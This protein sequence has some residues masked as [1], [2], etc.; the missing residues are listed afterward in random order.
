MPAAPANHNTHSQQPATFQHQKQYQQQQHQHQQHQQQQQQQH[1]HHAAANRTPSPLPRTPQLDFS[2]PEFYLT[3]VSA[4]LDPHMPY[5]HLQSTCLY[6][7]STA[8]LSSQDVWLSRDASSVSLSLRGERILQ[9][10]NYLRRRNWGAVRVQ[11]IARGWLARR[12]CDRI[13]AKGKNVARSMSTYERALRARQNKDM[14]A[15]PPGAGSEVLAEEEV[16]HGEKNAQAAREELLEEEKLPPR[17]R[18]LTPYMKDSDGSDEGSDR[19]VFSDMVGPE[20]MPARARAAPADTE[21]PADFLPPVRR[22]TV[23]ELPS[24]ETLESLREEAPK[25]APE[26]A[27][28]TP[29][30]PERQSSV[31]HPAL[32]AAGHPSWHQ[33]A[34]PAR[35]APPLTRQ[36]TRPPRPPQNDI[37][38]TL[39]PPQ[40]TLTPSMQSEPQPQPATLTPSMQSQPQPQTGQRSEIVNPRHSK[41]AVGLRNHLTRVSMA[42]EQILANG[43]GFQ[44]GAATPTTTEINFMKLLN[45]DSTFLLSANIAKLGPPEPADFDFLDRRRSANPE[46]SAAHYA[47]MSPRVEAWIRAT[48]KL[49]HHNQPQSDLMTHL[50]SG[51]ILCRLACEL[52]PRTQCQL[53]SKGAEFT[54]HKIIFFLELCKTVGV[55]NKNIFAVADL[56]ASDPVVDPGRRGPLK[57]VR[58]LHALERQVRRQ[59]W[60]GP[61]LETKI[62]PTQEEIAAAQAR[63]K[64]GESVY[65]MYTYARSDP[66]P[67]R[68]GP[69]KVQEV[70]DEKQLMEEDDDGG[71][72]ELSLFAAYDGKS[73]GERTLPR[74]NVTN[75]QDMYDRNADV[76]SDDEGNHIAARKRAD[77]S[78]SFVGTSDHPSGHAAGVKNA[79]ESDDDRGT[80]AGSP[81]S[82]ITASQGYSES[83]AGDHYDEGD[84]LHSD[85][86]S[87]STVRWYDT[88]RTSTPLTVITDP[89][90]GADE[91]AFGG[92]LPD[93]AVHMLENSAAVAARKEIL[94][95]V[96][97][98]VVEEAE[99]EEDEVKT[100]T[101]PGGFEEFGFRS[102]GPAAAAGSE[103]QGDDAATPTVDAEKREQTYSV[104]AAYD[105]IEHDLQPPSSPPSTPLPPSPVLPAINTRSSPAYAFLAGPPPMSALPRTPAGA[106]SSLEVPQPAP[107]HRHDQ[108]DDDA[109]SYPFDMNEEYAP[110]DAVDA[111]ASEHD[112]PA[113]LPTAAAILPATPELLAI[114]L[115]TPAPSPIATP[116]SMPWSSSQPLAAPPMSALPPSPPQEERV[117]L[118]PPPPP[119]STTSTTRAAAAVAE[120]AV[121]AQ[122]PPTFL[123]AEDAQRKLAKQRE[124]GIA[125][126]LLSEEI[127]IHDLALAQTYLAT[128]VRSRRDRRAAKRGSTSSADS[129]SSTTS[130]RSSSS[131][132]GSS[133]PDQAE[134]YAQFDVALRDLL[135]LHRRLLPHLRAAAFAPPPAA[136]GG[137]G[138]GGEGLSPPRVLASRILA[139]AT[140]AIPIYSTYAVLKRAVL[141]DGAD[142]AAFA[143]YARGCFKS[144]AVVEGKEGAEEVVD[145]PVR[146][147]GRLAAA[148]RVATRPE[149]AGV[150]AAVKIEQCVKGI[151]AA[152]RNL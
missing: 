142:V 104:Y 77:S 98:P 146:R 54:V 96:V 126:L 86:E 84:A 6:F 100:P 44:P 71:E 92:A 48:L 67:G 140:E 145:R 101:G 7:L 94:V 5:T 23:L 28:L 114:H 136:D 128:L 115:P 139:F 21:Q 29:N 12:R 10:L 151:E 72:Q 11:A 109:H 36:L 107:H 24:W 16:Q 14:L 35:S 80:R 38:I 47:D 129:S 42:Y 1:R 125:Q 65:S 39:Q 19:D 58:T 56:L 150:L 105:N 27:A 15:R 141:Q 4:A 108:D 95:P 83:A 55:K 22:L 143:A 41:R 50:R 116:S 18:V 17:V 133:L 73:E 102:T 2:I 79:Y 138:G 46:R 93:S 69:E 131:S 34:E 134:L 52:Y 91:W 127:F 81:M 120:T 119:P 74:A 66:V 61:K 117:G 90:S 20:P 111:T 13:R 45:S 70:K 68:D 3:F 9:D 51:D 137:G 132:S 97:S 110:Y 30:S 37:P 31:P 26:S 64:S 123:A 124:A 147:L 62:E 76:M 33:D 82:F 113:S 8:R 106:R 88:K 149:R 130:A 78:T 85:A 144:G 60:N 57:V 122:S 87:T 99:E 103:E 75:M 25:T 43:E 59:G 53:L 135:A 32:V 152:M 121:M 40:Q 118:P 63:P 49:P 148:V 89:L 112:L